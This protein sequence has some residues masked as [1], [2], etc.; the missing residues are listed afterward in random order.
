MRNGS[1]W[2]NVV[3]E[4]EVIFHEFDFETSDL[5]FEVSKSS[6]WKHTT[7]CDKGVFSFILSRNFDDQL[8]S[9]FHRFVILCI[10]WDTP[11]GKTGLW[12]LPIVS[13]V[14]KINVKGKQFHHPKTLKSGTVGALASLCRPRGA[15]SG[16]PL[17][18][19]KRTI[20]H[21]LVVTSCTW[22]QPQVTH[23]T[24]RALGADPG[25]PLEWRQSYSG[26]DR[27]R[28]RE[29]NRTH[30]LKLCALILFFCRLLVKLMTTVCY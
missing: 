29:A 11:S 3:F 5:E 14:F 28:R 4:K 6:I 30:P 25:E 7:L 15:H 22:G 8:S 9:N 20:T 10:C 18:R 16:E 1:L 23:S 26:A 17:T 27:G 24:S 2:S 12:Q 21:P 13:S 19:A